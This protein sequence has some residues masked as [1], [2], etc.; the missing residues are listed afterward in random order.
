M[1]VQPTVPAASP[2]QPGLTAHGP[3]TQPV[4]TGGPN[5][6]SSHAPARLPRSRRRRSSLWIIL[7]C[8]AGLVLLLSTG[9]VWAI[10]FRGPSVRTDLVTSRLEYKELQ[11]K[12]VE[13]GTLEAANPREVKCDVK[14]GSRGAPKILKVVENGQHVKPG[15]LL[16]EIDSSYLEEQRDA[17]QIDLDKAKADM[18]AA[19]ENYDILKSA[20]GLAEQ[21]YDKWVK[22]DYPQQE[23]DLEGQIKTAEANFHQQDDR[24][25]WAA[26]MVKKNYMTASQLEAEE[27]NLDGYRLNLQKL[28]EQLSVL[29]NYTDPVNKQ[30][31]KNAIE[32]AKNAERSGEAT[33]KSTE[34]VHTQQKKLFDDYESQIKQ[35][36]LY[37]EFEGNVVYYVPEQT[38][39]GAGTNQSIIA[40]GEPVQ[41]GQKML[42]IPDTEH[43]N[44][45][46]RIHEAFIN[47]MKEGLPVSVRVDALPGK[48]LRAHVKSVSPVAAQQDWMSPDV[49]VYQTYITI[50]DD[51]TNLKLKP[52]LSAACTIFTE[53]KSPGP[54]L[55][56]PIQAILSPAEKG[57]KPRCYIMTPHGPESREIEL[58]KNP[59]GSTLTDDKYAWVKDGLN[60]GDEIVLNPKVLLSD[61]EKK[62]MNDAKTGPQGGKGPPDGKGKGPGSPGRNGQPPAMK[63]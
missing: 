19:K 4:V 26:R 55:A 9:A 11:L 2:E 13:R 12:I 17:K 29:R 34:A 53:A 22:G 43:M 3:A 28:T 52:G 59:D 23:H 30:T 33:K 27:A 36:K 45:N 1:T 25:A 7:L 47:H 24:T 21:N 15:E 40:Q 5:G 14:A 10:W 61:K 60:E 18:I 49:K 51:L 54:V 20:I 31:L 58:G 38:M 46:V 48:T 44:V 41:Y 6:S 56:I 63:Q 39:R 62:A 35:C 57:G 8:A 50:D 37:A 42:S 32:A 16:V